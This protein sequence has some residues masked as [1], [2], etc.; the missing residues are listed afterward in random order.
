MD[1]NALLYLAAMCCKNGRNELALQ[2][3]QQ[4]CNSDE[5]SSLLSSSLQPLATCM[6]QA[7]TQGCVAEGKDGDGADGLNSY[8]DNIDSVPPTNTVFGTAPISENTISPS[9]HGNDQ[10]AFGQVVAMASAVFT[11]KQYLEDGEYL[12]IDPQISA[13]ASVDVEPYDPESL[14]IRQEKP[15]VTTPL[16]PG[17]I[18]I[19]L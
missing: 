8:V 14:A 18:R 9:L 16:Q 2:V 17:R 4:A 13:F 19:K 5:F 6:P 11:Q 12:L 10:V 15:K 3:L 7:V 1:T